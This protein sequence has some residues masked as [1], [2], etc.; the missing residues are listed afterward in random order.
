MNV[1]ASSSAAELQQA[2]V[3]T[4]E[5]GFDDEMEGELFGAAVGR[6]TSSL[7]KVALDFNWLLSQQSASGM[8]K[9]SPSDPR[10]L[11]Y[12]RKNI[13]EAVKEK[14]N[15]GFI[16]DSVLATLFALAALTLE[17]A[18]RKAEWQFMFAKGKRWVSKQLNCSPAE[19]DGLLALLS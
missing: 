13:S 2:S 4:I 7:P 1:G 18:P 11:Q 3:A 14:L 17:F 10:F 6:K 19:F 5:S 12:A 8:F 16:L 9:F 15:D